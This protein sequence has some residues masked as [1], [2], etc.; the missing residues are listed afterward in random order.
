MLTDVFFG[1][2]RYLL[3]S[4]ERYVTLP[5]RHHIEDRYLER[6]RKH[7]LSLDKGHIE[8]AEK[9]FQELTEEIE[10]AHLG[11]EYIQEISYRIYYLIIDV[12]ASINNTQKEEPILQRPEWRD[13]SFFITFGKWKD[14]NMLLIKEAFKFME[15]SHKMANLGVCG[16]VVEYIHRHYQESI[17]IKQVADLS[18]INS[19]Y[20]GRAFQKVIGI[21]FKQYLNDL[22]IA[23]A[24]RLLRQT[25]QL[26]YEIAN[27]V[28]YTE[29]KYFIEKFTKEVG[30]SPSEFRRS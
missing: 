8:E 5:L 25:D 18:F 26:I 1:A 9:D 23:E 12:M 30:I 10:L 16:E 22:R 11:M 6:L 28:G 21:G 20:L 4:P 13:Y 14:M 17:T 19:T 29:S 27:Q 7:L 15:S 2:S 3:Y 24:K